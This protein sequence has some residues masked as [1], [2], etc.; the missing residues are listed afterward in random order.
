LEAHGSRVMM[1]TD[2]EETSMSKEP[3]AGDRA[4]SR[5]L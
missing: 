3:V 4:A 5:P 1:A 2:R